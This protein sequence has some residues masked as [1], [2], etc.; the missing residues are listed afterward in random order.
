M[1]PKGVLSRNSLQL[2]LE[3]RPLASAEEMTTSMRRL[4]A[5]S[6]HSKK[7]SLVSKTAPLSK[8][9]RRGGHLRHV[10]HQQ[11]SSGISRE[12]AEILLSQATKTSV[13]AGPADSSTSESEEVQGTIG[14]EVN[15]KRRSARRLRDYFDENVKLQMLGTSILEDWQVG[16]KARNKYQKQLDKFMKFAE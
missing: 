2:L 7:S 15:R 9:L 14:S 16:K 10:L 13:V 3:G 1:V 12:A 5:S 11:I 4:R 6:S 8:R